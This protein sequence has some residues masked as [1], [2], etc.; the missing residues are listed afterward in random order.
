MEKNWLFKSENSEKSPNP[1]DI[2]GL[3]EWENEGGRVVE[4]FV[5]IITD[6]QK[7][8]FEELL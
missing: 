8:V 3:D 2:V 7:I 1:N 4:C 5:N 6:N